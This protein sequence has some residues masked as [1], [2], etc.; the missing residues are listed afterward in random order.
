MM[1]IIWAMPSVSTSFAKREGLE[2]LSMVQRQ[3]NNSGNVG[4]WALSYIIPLAVAWPVYALTHSVAA[5]V[6]AVIVGFVLFAMLAA[7]RR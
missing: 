1:N 4:T 2:Y 6:V 5:G 3:P 7:K